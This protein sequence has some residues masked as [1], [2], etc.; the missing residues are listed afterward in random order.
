MRFYI[1]IQ[2]GKRSLVLVSDFRWFGGL[3]LE[4]SS[5]MLDFGLG[6]YGNS[7]L[8]DEFLISSFGSKTTIIGE[9]SSSSNLGFKVLINE[10]RV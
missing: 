9:V 8:Q 10:L 1:L 2:E 3:S 4:F 5:R 6:S 7:I